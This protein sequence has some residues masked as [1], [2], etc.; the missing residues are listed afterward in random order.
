MRKQKEYKLTETGKI[1]IEWE[2]LRLD[3]LLSLEY[4]KGLP[5]R[6]KRK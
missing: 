5:E 2:L 6:E 3:A 1:P 4:G